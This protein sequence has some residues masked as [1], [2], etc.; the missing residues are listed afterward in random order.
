MSEMQRRPRLP[1][2]ERR[3]D[4]W[5]YR[6]FCE[7]VP[8]GVGGT[9][10]QF[11]IREAYYDDTDT[12]PHSWTAEPSTPFGDTKLA[13]MEDVT[14]MASAIS[15]PVLYLDDDGNAIGSEEVRRGS[16]RR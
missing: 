10:E 16:L 11:T 8:D 4:H 5:N 1:T 9:V 12:R 6:V 13:L 15:S 3:I 7:R 14:A 2:G